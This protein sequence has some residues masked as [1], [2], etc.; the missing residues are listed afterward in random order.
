MNDLLGLYI[1]DGDLAEVIKQVENGANVNTI[2]TIYTPLTIACQYGHHHIAEY[3]I[4]KGAD[5]NFT[6][7]GTGPLIEAV[8]NNN[9]ECIK[10]LLEAGADPNIDQWSIKYSNTGRLGF[11]GRLMSHVKDV[12]VLDILVKAGLNINQVDDKGRTALH[13]AVEYFNLESV[14]LLLKFGVN[15]DAIDNEG[16]TPLHYSTYHRLLSYKSKRIEMDTSIM[17]VLLKYNPDNTIRDNDGK[18]AKDYLPNDPDTISIVNLMANY[19]Y[20]DLEL[21]EP[22]E[23]YSI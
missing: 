6:N 19:Q 5:V 20:L 14:K 15:I 7:G 22:D 23:I 12:D 3:L 8:V 18:L 16:R 17:E 4:S 21:K 10:V 13:Q 1:F 11:R 9:I 2:I